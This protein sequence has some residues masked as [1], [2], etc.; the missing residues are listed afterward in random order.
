MNSNDIELQDQLYKKKPEKKKPAMVPRPQSSTAGLGSN[1]APL[2]AATV[3]PV[4]VAAVPP[5]TAAVP[6]PVPVDYSDANPENEKNDS[7]VKKKK[8]KG[9]V[10][11]SPETEK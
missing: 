5:V 10:N 9:T 8:K 4:N 1:F 11:A 7:V 6:G 3:P 2:S